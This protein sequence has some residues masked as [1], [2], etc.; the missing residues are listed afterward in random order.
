MRKPE[1]TTNSQGR[2]ILLLAI[3]ACFVILTGKS[4]ANTSDLPDIGS[5]SDAMLS[6]QL[7]ARVGRQVYY[8]ILQTGTVNTDP[9]IQEYIQAVGMELV[10]HAGVQDQSFQFFVVNNNVINAFAFPGGYIG[11][12][13]GLILAT[14]NESELAGVMA[15]EISH[16]TQRHISRAVFAN[17]RASTISL[18]A[19][20]GA[21]VV[22]VATGADADLIAGAVGV[23]QGAA[24]EQQIKFT[25]TNEYEADRVGISLLADAGFDP[26]AMTDFFETM[27]RATGSLAG[28]APEF[29]LTHPVSSDRMAEARSRA[30]QYPTVEVGNSAG[31]EITRARVRLLTAKRPDLA[32]EQF[33]QMAKEEGQADSFEIRYGTAISLAAMGRYAEAAPLFEALLEQ[34]EAIVP[35]HSGLALNQA[36]MGNLKQSLAT[37]E[38]AMS[39]FPRN[40]PLTVRYCETLLNNG[41]AGDA[42]RILLDLLNTVPPTLEQVRLIAMAANEAGDISEAHY[43]M[44]EYHAMNGNLRLAIEQLAQAL[45]SPGLDNVERQRYTARLK[46]FQEYLPQGEQ[47]KSER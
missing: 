17:Q 43:Y 1:A 37:F 16:V 18:A 42:H 31:Y 35:L 25:R 36:Q 15:H 24:I 47:R 30:R 27:G 29:M 38:N 32:L 8:S 23:T 7:E 20:L 2:Q 14:A 33:R 5:P 19:L 21:I 39:L 12:H 6:K 28:R 26:N 10:G 46:Q 41:R 34:N 45:Q 13:S 4:A 11:T 22:G 40:V 44:A 9:E 3:I